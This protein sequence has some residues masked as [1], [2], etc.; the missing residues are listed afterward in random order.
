MQNAFSTTFVP[1]VCCHFITQQVLHHLWHDH[2]SVGCAS[3]IDASN[4]WILDVDWV[5]GGALDSLPDNMTTY[6]FQHF[7][8]LNMK[9]S[10]LVKAWTEQLHRLVL[11]AVF[12]WNSIHFKPSNHANFYLSCYLSW[13]L[14][15][16]FLAGSSELDQG[17][18][19]RHKGQL[20]GSSGAPK[21]Q[22]FQ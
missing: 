16:G 4:V 2:V 21:Q 5:P 3:A 10:W 22:L 13:Y 6:G 1:K 9:E 12:F 17:R 19:S 18:V 20:L 8:Y 15:T 7:F 14:F 11:F